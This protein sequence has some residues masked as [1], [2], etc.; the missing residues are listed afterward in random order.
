[1]LQVTTNAHI[2][3]ALRKKKVER[4]L[5]EEIAEKVYEGDHNHPKQQQRFKNM[6]SGLQQSDNGDLSWI[7]HLMETNAIS[8]NSNEINLFR[9]PAHAEMAHIL[10][11]PCEARIYDGG[12]QTDTFRAVSTTFE[13][14]IRARS[15]EPNRKKRYDFGLGVPPDTDYPRISISESASNPDTD[16]IFS[17]PSIFVSVSVSES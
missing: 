10:H 15:P 11:N 16:I 17:H 4:S 12:V 5:D 1:M 7:N 14:E 8:D 2:Q 9:G 13:F 3:N 6:A